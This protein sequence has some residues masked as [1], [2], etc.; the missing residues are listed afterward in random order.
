LHI[1]ALNADMKAIFIDRGIRER[2]YNSKICPIICR[3]HHPLWWFSFAW[4]QVEL[5]HAYNIFT[6]KVGLIDFI[7][8]NLIIQRSPPW[9]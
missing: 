2:A 1:Y 7:L 4:T 5:Y 9:V 3:R 6:Y 8:A